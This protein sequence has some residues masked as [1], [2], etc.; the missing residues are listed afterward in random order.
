MASWDGKKIVRWPAEC[1]SNYP[2]WEIVDH[3]CCAGL[4]WGGDYPRE[5]DCNMGTLYHHKPSG[6]YALY[7]GGPLRGRD[8][9]REMRLT[10]ECD[11]N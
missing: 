11:E 5:C 2:D 8:S 7:P 10:E 6:I 4:E 3:G 1:D 9:K